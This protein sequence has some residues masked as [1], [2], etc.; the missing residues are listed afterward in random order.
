MVLKHS[1]RL[2]NSTVHLFALFYQGFNM[3]LALDFN[4]IENN[5][6]VLSI[7]FPEDSQCIF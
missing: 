2:V 7:M 6:F 3:L 5:P 4:V 1:S